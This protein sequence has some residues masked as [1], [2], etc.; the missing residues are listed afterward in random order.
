MATETGQ[1]FFY[2]L[3]KALHGQTSNE[4]SGESQGHT[5]DSYVVNNFCKSL[6][7]C[8]A[9]TAGDEVKGIQTQCILLALKALL[10]WE[11]WQIT[12]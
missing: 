7:G 12:H 6:F 10:R 9:E 2:I 8:L 11:M 3:L 5:D 1:L 4:R